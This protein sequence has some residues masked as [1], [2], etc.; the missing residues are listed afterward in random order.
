MNESKV[1]TNAKKQQQ[2]FEMDVMTLSNV[3]VQ[4]HKCTKVYLSSLGR[5]IY[6]TPTV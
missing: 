3:T 5:G 4:T 2:C 6:S 1:V